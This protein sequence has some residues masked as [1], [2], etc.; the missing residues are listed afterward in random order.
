MSFRGVNSVVAQNCGT[1]CPSIVGRIGNPSYGGIDSQPITPIVR[2]AASG[3]AVTRP[4][5]LPAWRIVAAFDHAFAGLIAAVAG[6]A[7]ATLPHAG[8]GA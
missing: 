2:I 3:S 4:E 8:N 1:D 5:A 7:V 6:I